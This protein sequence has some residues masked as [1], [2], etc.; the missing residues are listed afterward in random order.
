MLGPFGLYFYFFE[1][2]L[3]FKVHGN[4]CGIQTSVALVRASI[5]LQVIDFYMIGVGYSSLIGD[6]IFYL[7][8]S[9]EQFFLFVESF[10]VQ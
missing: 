10:R 8:L 9:H 7:I 6:L 5:L 1:L 2:W 4:F 3:N